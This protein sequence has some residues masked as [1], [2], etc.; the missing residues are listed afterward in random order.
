MP[1]T[2]DNDKAKTNAETVSLKSVIVFFGFLYISGLFVDVRYY[3][4]VE[5]LLSEKN[6]CE[7]VQKVIK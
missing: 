3:K 6:V 7:S 5:A 4:K 2:C 1:K